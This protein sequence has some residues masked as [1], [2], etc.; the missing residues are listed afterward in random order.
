V[1]LCILG[2]LLFTT[3]LKRLKRIND[4]EEVGG[5]CAGIA[6]WLGIP[7]WIVRVIWAI[8]IIYYGVGA[9]LYIILWIFVPRW[10]EDPSDY[11]EI[12]G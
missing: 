3:M 12:S 2:N 10:E 1:V 9:G 11:E 4:D 5:V 6:Y 8:S 7:T